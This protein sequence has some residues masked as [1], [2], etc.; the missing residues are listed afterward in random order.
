MRQRRYEALLLSAAVLL[1][2]TAFTI[3]RINLDV[4]DAAPRLQFGL[5]C[6]LA[7]LAHL[8]LRRFAPDADQVILPVAVLLNLLGLVMLHRLDVADRTR[9]IRQGSTPPDPTF[10]TQAA[11]TM[12]GLSLM[13]AVVL[14]VVSHERLQRYTYT[15]MVLG[16]A[17]LLLPL[18]PVVGSTINGAR[19]WVRIGEA[20]FQPGEFG[21]LFLALFFAGFLVRKRATLA[22]IRIRHWGLGVPRARDLGPIVVAWAASVVILVLERDLGMSLLVF[23][24]FVTTLYLATAQ[25]TW[26]ALGAMLFVAGAAAAYLAFP[27]ARARVTIWLDPFAHA[28]G[29]GYQ[30]VQ[31]LYG[32]ASGGLFGSGLGDGFPYLIPYARNDFILSAF[33]EELGLVGL[34][35]LLLCFAVLVQRGL[36]V[37]TRTP[38]TFGQLLAGGI[39][40]LIGLQA[41][42][43][44]GGVT[45]LIPLTG[46]TTP[47]LSA[48]GSSLVA[49]WVSIGVLLR[50]SDAANRER[51]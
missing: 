18:L 35:A 48:G 34:T 19:L 15:S 42:I 30:L 6:L 38:D 16:L 32:L 7:V 4:T 33:G 2:L 49:S 13:V 31:S 39:A 17:L 47:F 37:A 29:Q 3:A 1:G 50:I 36:H 12:L 26:L 28:D 21:K 23:G 5:V 51:A 40:V 45:R 22:T 27:H 25:R 11:W 8:G 14:L 43:V 10:T 9:A 41:F 20:S 46:L 24:L 44:A